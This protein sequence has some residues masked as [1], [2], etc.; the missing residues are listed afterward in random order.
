MDN[1]TKTLNTLQM[2]DT[3]FSSLNEVLFNF[4]NSL[5]IIKQTV[6]D[7]DFSDP[8]FNPFTYIN[9]DYQLALAD[10]VVLFNNLIQVKK[11]QNSGLS[12]KYIYPVTETIKN[13]K[14]FYAHSRIIPN[15]TSEYRE[16]AR[17]VCRYDNVLIVLDGDT[18][19]YTFTIGEEEF[20]IM[21]TLTE[22]DV[23]DILQE[24]ADI[25]T[26][27]SKL[28]G[29]IFINSEAVQVCKDSFVAIYQ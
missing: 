29:K 10:A 21:G 3:I 11:S 7:S 15:T 19:D 25:E 5:D 12:D 8:S 9:D 23:P 22:A 14:V 6:I 4:K 24:I 27:V 26:V 1:Y 18:G 17:E 13:K 16:P 28:Q 2:V 20:V